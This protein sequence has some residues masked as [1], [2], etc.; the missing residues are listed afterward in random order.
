MKRL[1]L[2][3][4]L[5]IFLTFFAFDS[6]FLTPYAL[7]TGKFGE[8]NPIHSFFLGKF[9]YLYPLTTF[10]IYCFFF[11]KAT[12]FIERETDKKSKEKNMKFNWFLL[13]VVA[14]WA[15]IE[16]FAIT[17]NLNQLGVI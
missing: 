13:G 9:G 8:M 1:W 2:K 7:S 3:I 12:N 5:I 4:F 11:F 10:P 15:V 16:I 6:L 17:N 14:F